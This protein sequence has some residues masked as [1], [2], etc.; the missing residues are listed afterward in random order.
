MQ[1]HSALTLVLAVNLVS[2]AEQRMGEAPFDLT[3]DGKPGCFIVIAEKPSPSARLAAL[4]LQSHVLKISGA[5][6]PIRSETE[7]IDG[8]RILVGESSATRELGLRSKDFS[9]QEYLISFRMNSV[10]L[11]GRDWDDTEANR[12]VEGRPMTG[13]S[14]QELRHKVNYW[15]A[16]GMSERSSGQIELPGLYDDQGTCLATYDFLERFCG[17]RWYGPSA[18]TVVCPQRATL[19]IKGDDLRRS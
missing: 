12:N 6:L 13:E 18:V 19:T 7:R 17:V 15:E 10:I 9:S 4:E 14:L 1:V 16:V 2:A 8:R 3:R 5:E 11:I